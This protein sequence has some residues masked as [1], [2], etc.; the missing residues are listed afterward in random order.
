MV[1]VAAAAGNRVHNFVAA[2]VDS[3]RGYALDGILTVPIDFI[4]TRGPGR[5]SP[6][7]APFQGS[8]PKRYNPPEH[9]DTLLNDRAEAG[10][11]GKRRLKSA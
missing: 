4:E 8:V 9:R 11:G 1:Q 10:T 5:L 2:D 6:V 7:Y 3:T